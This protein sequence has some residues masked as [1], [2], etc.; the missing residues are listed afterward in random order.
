MQ[1]RRFQVNQPSE[2]LLQYIHEVLL[3][4]FQARRVDEHL[5]KFS[6][7]PREEEGSLSRSRTSK[8]GRLNMNMQ[9][10]LRMG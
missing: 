3:G 8:M 9:A 6:A 4:L 5:G 2:I 7:N 10:A 1:P